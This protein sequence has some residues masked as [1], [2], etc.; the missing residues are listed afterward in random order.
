MTDAMQDDGS[1]DPIMLFDET[2]MPV[3][4]FDN[5]W[6]ARLCSSVETRA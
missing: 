1:F 4:S 3:W 6:R 5:R 2:D